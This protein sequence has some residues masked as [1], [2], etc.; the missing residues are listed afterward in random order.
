MEYSGNEYNSPGLSFIY[1]QHQLTI[2]DEMKWGSGIQGAHTSN[3]D[4]VLVCMRVHLLQ[5]KLLG[6]ISV[7]AVMRYVKYLNCENRDHMEDKLLKE[8]F[9]CIKSWGKET[10]EICIVL[11]PAGMQEMVTTS[12]KDNM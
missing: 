4:G 5:H 12:N 10:P 1:T 6:I 7:Y 2:Y 3:M 11:L 8:I 9:K